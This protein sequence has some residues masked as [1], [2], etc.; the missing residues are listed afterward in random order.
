[1][2]ITPLCNVFGK[3]GGCKFQDIEYSAQI[4]MKRNDIYELLNRTGISFSKEKIK[5]YFK[6]EYYY[7]NRMDFIIS[8][9]GCGLREK[10]KFYKIINFNKCYIA[11]DRINELLQEINGW[12]KKDIQK[13]EIFDI[14]KKTGILRYSVIRTGIF[15]GD[16]LITFIL[17]KDA[18]KE[19]IDKIIEKIKLF[20]EK[21]KALKVLY[22][23][24]R[25]N[26]DVSI[27]DEFVIL[28]GNEF[29]KERLA[30]LNYYYHSQG[31]FQSNSGVAIDMI[32]YIKEKIKE[33]YDLLF[34]MFGG[35]GTFGIFMSEY[36]KDVIIFD[37]NKYA[38][39]CANKNIEI[40]NKTNIKF[41]K[42]DVLNIENLLPEVKGRKSIYIIDPPR[43]GLHKKAIKFILETLP[44]KIFY[45]SCN[46]VKFI[47]DYKNID[48]KYDIVDF[49][50]FDMFPQTPHIESVAE[51]VKI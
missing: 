49:A 31:F 25:H 17:N 24:V 15:T 46:P 32:F 18:E 33:K 34:D 30:N 7:R 27:T 5:I 9:D 48:K 12:I 35:V 16:T 43:A 51:L 11:A 47:E 44:E 4:A 10:G 21:T 50:L 1:M 40:N 42:Q 2:K 8:L 19:K 36:A 26:T 37:N 23:F 14:K 38:E 29:I 39:I 28:K 20:T 41:I 6:N 13:E 22:G 45:I 3:C